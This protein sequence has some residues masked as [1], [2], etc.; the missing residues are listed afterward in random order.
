MQSWA[1]RGPVEGEIPFH[2]SAL[3]GLLEILDQGP[4]EPEGTEGVEEA[5]RVLQ[6]HV[7]PSGPCG[8]VSALEVE[9]LFGYA[10]GNRRG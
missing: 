6:V 1:G 3:C 5:M 8:A 10:V 7:V 9:D 4:S 2:T